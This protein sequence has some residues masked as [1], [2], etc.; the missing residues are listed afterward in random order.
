MTKTGTLM[1]PKQR[2]VLVQLYRM[3]KFIKGKLAKFHCNHAYAVRKKNF[4]NRN[5]AKK[6]SYVQIERCEAANKVLTKSKIK[7]NTVWE[8]HESLYKW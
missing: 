3:K 5:Y 2:K 4:R 7:S 8:C 6:Y 1:D